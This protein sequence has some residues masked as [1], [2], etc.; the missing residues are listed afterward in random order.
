MDMVYFLVDVV[1]HTETRKRLSPPSSPSTGDATDL[2]LRVSVTYAQ[3]AESILTDRT[4]NLGSGFLSAA[5]W[6]VVDALPGL[7]LLPL[8]PV[9]STWCPR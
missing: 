7:P 6:L 8:V 3:V 5:L 1:D 2:H 9:T 4:L